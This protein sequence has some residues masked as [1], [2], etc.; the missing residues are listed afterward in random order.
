MT[1]TL[2]TPRPHRARGWSLSLLLVLLQAGTT[3]AFDA[4]PGAARADERRTAAYLERIRDDPNRLVPFLREMPKGADLHN[5]A[6][7]AVYA[8]SYLRWGAADGLCVELTT[9]SLSA[10]PCAGDAGRPE[11]AAALARDGGLHDRLVNAWSMRNRDKSPQNGHDLFFDAFAKFDAATKPRGGDII[12]EVAARAGAANLQYLELM[13]N[14]DAGA[15]RAAGRRVGWNDDFSVMHAALLAP[16]PRD[17]ARPTP[18]YSMTEIVAGSRAWLDGAEARQ[19]ALLGCAGARPDP[20]CAVTVRYLY[21][22]LRALPPEMVFAQ[23]VFAFEL[24]RADPRAVGVNLVQPEDDP[25]AVAGFG[26]QMRMLDWL[27]GVY[28]GVRI[29]LHAG[30]LAPGLV[31][32]EVLRF[33]VRD[34]VV[35]GHA[36]RIGHGV[37]VMHEDDPY[38]LLRELAR[39][40]VLVEVCLTS[41]DLILGV[42]GRDHPLATLI[43]FGV[44]VA[45]ATDDEGVARSDIVG[46]YRRAV[47]DQGLSYGQLKRM[48]R[49]SLE[50][51]FVAGDSLWTSPQATTRVAACARDFPGAAT[52]TPACERHLADNEKARLQMELEA[53]LARFEATIAGEAAAA[54]R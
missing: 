12:A 23:M 4:P 22:V 51:A 7:G 32:P 52:R 54:R 47:T 21:Q 27:H 25:A 42:R 49:A 10:P 6:S 13:L 16:V 19:R 2:A 1:P 41:N 9:M 28:P 29:T 46:E 26:L 50:H 24:A 20:G 31:P 48:A 14:P 30:E 18:A 37:D 33:H 3:A 44:P 38:G 5:H 40:N 39:R 34:S 8:E 36:S 35:V 15:A 43:R 53:R 17:D 11:L 45:L